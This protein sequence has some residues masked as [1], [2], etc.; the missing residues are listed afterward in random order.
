MT[1]TQRVAMEKALTFCEEW[2]SYGG[3]EV[4]NALRAALNEPAQDSTSD[5]RK[6]L[7]LLNETDQ[8]QQP[9]PTTPRSEPL[10]DKQIEAGREATFSTSNPF[11]PC[12][13]K[14]MRKVVRW[15]EH[16]HG[17]GSE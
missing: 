4:A 12:D 17:I 13:S 9:S 2:Y 10:T 14:T 7:H 16:A 11:C 6:M 1:E 3:K 15:A 8:A 5:L